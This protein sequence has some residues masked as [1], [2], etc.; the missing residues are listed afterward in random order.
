MKTLKIIAAITS[1]A[2]ATPALAQTGNPS[3]SAAEMDRAMRAQAA[4]LG[5][6]AIDPSKTRPIYNGTLRIDPRTDPW[7]PVT[8]EGMHQTNQD[9]WTSKPTYSLR[10]AVDFDGDGNI[11]AAQAYNNSKQGAVIVTFGGPKPRAPLVVYKSDRQFH[12]GEEIVAAGRNRILVNV[13][14]ARSI[15]LFMYRGQP[16]IMVYGD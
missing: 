15:L 2:A 1:L 4:R 3:Q 11:D 5:S 16:R 12:S 10:I 7:R 6:V 13:P 9:P 14:D 8:N